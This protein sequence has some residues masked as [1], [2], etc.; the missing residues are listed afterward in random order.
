MCFRFVQQLGEDAVAAQ[1][2]ANR[3]VEDIVWHGLPLTGRMREELQE[4][5]CA[6]FR[7]CSAAFSGVRDRQATRDASTHTYT[8]TALA[9]TDL[10]L[11]VGSWIGPGS[12]RLRLQPR[13]RLCNRH[14]QERCYQAERTR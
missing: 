12:G 9:R 8:H 7:T 11:S 2:D 6:A 1:K 3:K 10:E 4:A 13:L 5:H 14:D